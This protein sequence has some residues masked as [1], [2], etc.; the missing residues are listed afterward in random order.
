MITGQMLRDAII[1]AAKNFTAL[2]RQVDAMNV[3]PVPTED[4]GTNMLLTIQAAAREVGILPD[5]A[6]I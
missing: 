2:R 6:S 4:T 3:F 1:S 5:D